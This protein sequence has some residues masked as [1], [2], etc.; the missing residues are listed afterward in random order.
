LCLERR[1]NPV[2]DAP[3]EGP[4]ANGDAEAKCSYSQDDEA[5]GAPI[6]FIDF[7]IRKRA[8]INALIVGVSAHA[9]AP[10]FALT[11]IGNARWL[12][13]RDPGSVP[14]GTAHVA[15]TSYAPA[16]SAGGGVSTA[17]GWPPVGLTAWGA[18]CS[19]VGRM[20]RR[21]IRGGP[22]FHAGYTS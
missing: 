8:N 17:S 16:S 2:F 9:R 14:S 7:G 19:S 22:A 10:C 4:V 20:E 13:E 12:I 11:N 18:W 5:G 6:H 21:E 1:A 15:E 3:G